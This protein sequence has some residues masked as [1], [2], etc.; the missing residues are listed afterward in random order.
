MDDVDKL[1]IRIKNLEMNAIFKFGSQ[2]ET[3]DKRLL[4]E[5]YSDLIEL[6]KK[7]KEITN[8]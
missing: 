2:G 8:K 1:R 6:R 7:L 5:S 4:N 3:P